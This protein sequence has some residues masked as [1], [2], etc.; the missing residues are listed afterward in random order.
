MLSMTPLDTGSEIEN[1]FSSVQNF[2]DQLSVVDATIGPGS[3]RPSYYDLL[4]SRWS[5]SKSSLDL[6]GTLS[7]TVSGTHT[8]Q[9]IVPLAETRDPRSGTALKIA[10]SSSP[11][12]SPSPESLTI[13]RPAPIESQPETPPSSVGQSPQV[14]YHI[15]QPA[16]C[17]YRPLPPLSP[18]YY[19][20]PRPG[21]APP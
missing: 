6:L 17:Y 13:S 3:T 5:N 8:Q 16:P 11:R 2:D 4:D 1:R 21:V 20:V 12:D 9:V 7:S 15:P 19:Q 18:Y 10:P 14:E